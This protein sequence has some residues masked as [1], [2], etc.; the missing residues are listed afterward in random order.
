M[1]AVF[2]TCIAVASAI[3][4]TAPLHA[5]T[6]TTEA[7][8][9]I[10]VDFFDLAFTQRKPTEAALKYISPTTYI[11]HNPQGKDGR[12]TFI[13]GFAKYVE[14]GTLRCTIKRTIAQDDLVAVHN[15]CVDNPADPKDRGTAYVDIFR[16]QGGK[17]VEH[18]DV[19][20]PV[21]EKSANNNTMF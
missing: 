14:K 15:H 12:D 21:P 18:W 5:Q 13:N 19:G 7:N 1:K 16:V 17:I 6:N 10:V 4:V 20:Q 9:K 3:A 11:Q 2:L 8:K